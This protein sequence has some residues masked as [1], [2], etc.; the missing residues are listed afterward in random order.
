MLFGTTY[1]VAA[2]TSRAGRQNFP[3]SP[4]LFDV[5]VHGGRPAVRGIA[6]EHPEQDLAA[7]SF[8]RGDVPDPPR[9]AHVRRVRLYAPRHADGDVH[10]E[11]AAGRVPALPDLCLDRPALGAVATGP[12][13]RPPGHVHGRVLEAEA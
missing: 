10:V 3:G 13:G 11:A 7:R 9:L 8:D 6:L 1:S 2:V 4:P 5:D 12:E